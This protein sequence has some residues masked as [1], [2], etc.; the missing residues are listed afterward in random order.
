MINLSKYKDFIKIKIVDTGL[1]IHKNDISM[2]F[3]EFNQ[4]DNPMQ[5]K[6]NGTGLGLYIVKKIIDNIGGK[7]SV[8]SKEEEGTSFVILYPVGVIEK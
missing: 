1:G 8:K 4:L 5:K 3:D 2:I 6:C 7:I